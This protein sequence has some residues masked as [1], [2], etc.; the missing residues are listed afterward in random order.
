MRPVRIAG[1]TIL[2][3][4]IFVTLCLGL[5]MLPK[6]IFYLNAGTSKPGHAEYWSVYLGQP[7]CTLDRKYPGEPMQKVTS[8]LD[9]NLLSNGYVSCA[10][11]CEKGKIDC[12][13]VMKIKVDTGLRDLSMDSIDCIYDYGQKVRTT[14]GVT[15][16]FILDIEG[17]RITPD[18]FTMTEYKAMGDSAQKELK[19]S[20]EDITLGAL[21]FSKE[22]L[23]WAMKTM[24]EKAKED[25]IKG[26]AH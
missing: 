16:D 7:Q 13:P 24:A 10:G 15:G 5:S 22:G 14:G 25:S 4:A 9:L 19:R 20:G 17:N 21:A 11:Y 18:Q 1:A 2:L 23:A 26:A 3:S 12:S 6:P 8:G